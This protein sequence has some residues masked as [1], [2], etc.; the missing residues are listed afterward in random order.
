MTLTYFRRVICKQ[1]SQLAIK[2]A[3]AFAARVC[4]DFEIEL[5]ADIQQDHLTSIVEVK[6]CGLG[7]ALQLAV[8]GSFCLFTSVF[9]D[10]G[11]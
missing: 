11:V 1:L 7:I 9:R 4:G 10:F 5:C 6:C 2:W 3:S 8:A